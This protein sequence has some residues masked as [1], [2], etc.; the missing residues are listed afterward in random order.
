MID[1]RTK[2]FYFC[3]FTKII[4]GKL[5]HWIQLASNNDELIDFLLIDRSNP[6]RKV[7]YICIILI[8]FINLIVWYVSSVW[9]SRPKVWKTIDW[10]RA[11]GL[12]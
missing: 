12:R 9:Y 1:L 2:I 3:K 8:T 10:Y 6:K 5:S 11:P 7:L 4:T